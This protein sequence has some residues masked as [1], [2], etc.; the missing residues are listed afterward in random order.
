MLQQR[1]HLQLPELS[2]LAVIFLELQ[3]FD[4]TAG[5]TIT[6]TIANDA[7]EQAMIADDAVG[8]DQLAS[9]AVVNASVASGCCNLRSVRWKPYCITSVSVRF[10]RRCCGYCCHGNRIGFVGWWFFNR[11]N[12]GI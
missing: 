11:N 2:Q 4:G 10:K 9:N 7:V 5:I 3:I 8:A 12:C 6:S 1:L